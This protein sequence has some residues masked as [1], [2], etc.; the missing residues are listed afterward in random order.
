MSF[1]S[2]PERLPDRTLPSEATAR[3][4]NVAAIKG[5]SAK[6]RKRGWGLGVGAGGRMRASRASHLLKSGER[7]ERPSP[8]PHPQPPPPFPPSFKTPA[9]LSS[10]PRRSSAPPSP[11]STRLRA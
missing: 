1:S 11:S 6:T 8:S 9:S 2:S 4:K 5:S 3:K 7:S 10:L